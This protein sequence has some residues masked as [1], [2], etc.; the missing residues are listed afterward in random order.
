[1]KKATTT[2]DAYTVTGLEKFINRL[3]T[4]GYT[5]NWINFKSGDIIEIGFYGDFGYRIESID[6]KAKKVTMGEGV[7]I[8]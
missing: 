8:E 2:Q 5:V 6:H 4:E 7:W 3:E 1:M